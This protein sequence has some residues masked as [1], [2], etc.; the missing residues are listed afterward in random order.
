M[1]VPTTKLTPRH[2][3]LLQLSSMIDKLSDKYR[4]LV[5]QS[6]NYISTLSRNTIG[7]NLRSAYLRDLVRDA[8]MDLTK[9]HAE[10]QLL[11]KQIQFDISASKRPYVYRAGCPLER[12][13]RLFRLRSVTSL[14]LRLV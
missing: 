11:K 4:R 6:E 14:R 5:F 13:A 10:Y 1:L 3:R 9:A 2:R 7:D 12:K 8:R